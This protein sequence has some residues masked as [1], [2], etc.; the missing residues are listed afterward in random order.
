MGTMNKINKIKAHTQKFGRE[1]LQVGMGQAFAALGGLLGV[2]LLTQVMTPAS[3]GE[4]ALGMTFLV[5][6]Q[7]MVMGPISGSFARFFPVAHETHDLSAYF[8]S[9]KR[10]LLKAS[11]I[12]ALL[13][14]AVLVLILLAGYQNWTGLLL[15]SFLFTL[16]SS[17]NI[18]L[19][20]IQN[21]ARHRVV[22]AWHQ[23][24]SQWLRFV[25]ASGL[26][27][28]FGS[29]SIY[30]MLGYLISAIL[31]ILSQYYFFKKKLLNSEEYLEGDSSLPGKN[32]WDILM[33][34]YAQP[35]FLWGIFTWAQMSS[36]RWALQVFHS[37][38]DVG[39]YT[40]LYQ[41]GYYPISLL[42]G[43]FVQF[44]TPILFRRAGSGKHDDRLKSVHTTTNHLVTAAFGFTG[45]AVILAWILRDVIFSLLVSSG[46]REVSYLLPWMVLSGGLFATGQI[47]SLTA[48]NNNE[49]YKLLKPKIT[50]GVLG[51]IL[52]VVGAYLYGI[53]GVVFAGV[54][55]SA[56]YLIWV[57]IL[58]RP[59]K[60]SSHR[61]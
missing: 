25:V 7:Q 45:L 10:S 53:V 15:L 47:C 2:R 35:F 58:F 54:T 4:L 43:I 23:G 29:M 14:G 42:T 1:L 40:V 57:Y 16:I 8:N 22:V 13:C 55:F 18:V 33:T 9:V 60:A 24:I 5:L 32:D 37:S 44:V 3:Y 48:L 46:F 36:D 17:F 59:H 27:L 26:I 50:T 52:N 21:A 20:N 28:I 12:I 39:L 30:A 61:V 6:S 38:S 56:I 51:T 34:R 11:G 41:L 31:V 49:P 19:D